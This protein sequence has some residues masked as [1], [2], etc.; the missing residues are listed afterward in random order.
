MRSI[1]I[2]TLGLMLS[3]PLAGAAEKPLVFET[4]IRPILK[5]ACFH[6]HGEDEVKK[7]ELDVRLVRLMV[8]GG[9]S[10]AALAPGDH[11]ASLLWEK[12][13]SDE[14]PKGEKKL[15]AAEKD[16]IREWIAQGAKT[17]RPE[18]ENV[19]DARFTLEELE[20]WAFQAVAAHTPPEGEANPIDAFIRARLDAEGLSF[21]EPADRRTLIRRASIDVTGLPPSP[22]EVE[23]FISDPSTE[24][25]DKLI[26]RLLGSSQFG[27]RWARHWL[28][29]A[30]YAESD[31]LELSAR[32]RD[33]AWRYRDYVIDA[34]NRNKPIDQFITEQ[35]AGDELIEGDLDINNPLHLE[36]LTATGFLRMAPDATQKSNTLSDRNTAVAAAMQVVSSSL[37]GIT[38]ACAQCHDHKYDPIGIDDYYS[39]R[40]IFD[41][42][43]PLQNW[44]QPGNRLVDMTTAEV[45]AE[46]DRIEAEAKKV[47]DDIQARRLAHCAEI[48]KKKLADVPEDVREATRVAVLTKADER[49]QQ[50]KRLLDLYPMVKPVD[51]ISGLLVEYDGA[52]HRKFEEEKKKSAAIRA[53]KPPLRLVMATS[54]PAGAAASQQG[55]FSRQSGEPKRG[56]GT[57]RTHGAPT[58]PDRNAELPNNAADRKTTGRRLAYARQL[59]DGAHPLTARVFVNRVWMHHFGRGLVA[60]PGDFGIAGEM[61]SHPELL[62]WL[63]GDFVEHGWD[64]KRL[65]RMILLSK[66]YRQRSGRRPRTGSGRSGEPAARSHQSSPH[67]GGGCARCAVVCDATVG[68]ATRWPVEPGHREL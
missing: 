14:M 66:T 30:G 62:D 56:G 24:A 48:Q 5:V 12:I 43:F 45:S 16:R 15:A 20:H 57:C 50:Q 29:A 17:A 21:S 54:E 65:H 22:E 10:G 49:D 53:K 40:A 47:D 31:G 8:E 3:V 25:Y 33:H 58:P 9:E 60:T 37:L 55:I 28:D 67:G 68:S 32:K 41:P 19:E 26:D 27:V 2:T 18:P 4:D 64:Q 23:A 36:L 44:Q 39:F 6:C 34:F 59:T 11:D 63:A 1:S 52:A 13:A 51:F 46:R 35:L 7:G 42:V 38:V 61:P